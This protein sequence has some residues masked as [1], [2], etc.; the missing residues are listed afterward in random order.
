MPVEKFRAA[1]AVYGVLR[2]GDRVLLMRRAGSGHHD[3]ELSLPAGHVDGGEDVRSALVRELAEELG[4]EVD[5]E[6]CRLSAVAHRAPGSP[7]DHEYIDLFFTLDRWA[8]TPSIGEP[9]KCS[10][11]LW[12]GIDD[13]PSDTIDYVRRAILACGTEETLVLDG[14]PAATNR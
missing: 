12:A 8:G 4:I 1:V 13:L 10:E 2:D 6:A 14:W 5:P 11:L 7:T 9:D 3:G